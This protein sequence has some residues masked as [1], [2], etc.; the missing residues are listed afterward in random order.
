MTSPPLIA[1]D[2]VHI[3]FSGRDVL[4]GI[5]FQVEPGESLAI[6]GG[7]GVGKSVTLKLIT[8]LLEADSGLV[9][10]EGN[11]VA[12]MSRRRRKL[13][14]DTVG[15]LFQSGGLFDSLIVWENVCFGQIMHDKMPRHAARELAIETLSMVGLSPHVADL[16]PAEL[17]GGMR[18][19][20]GLARAIVGEPKV[21]LY[22][23]PTTGL[24]PISSDVISTLID[25]LTRRLGIASVII[26][27]NMACVRKTADRVLMLHDGKIVWS[28]KT[29]E[30]DKSSNPWIVQF[31]NGHAQG[32]V[33]ALV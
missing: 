4:K 26:T 16:W 29:S 8:G 6:V 1:V 15:M 31:I 18:K 10:Y 23:E 13:M 14:M 28:G 3:G 24:D 19:R 21:V 17:S 2:N 11:D 22:D 30:M 12:R 25:D 32:P 9:Q 20:V 27:H 33:T 7:S 5:T